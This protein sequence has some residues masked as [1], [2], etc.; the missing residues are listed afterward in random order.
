MH[1]WTA[2]VTNASLQ[3]L[4]Q[5]W[6]FLWVWKPRQTVS[7][8]RPKSLHINNGAR[9]IRTRRGPSC[10]LSSDSQRHRHDQE[11][12]NR[13]KEAAQVVGFLK[14]EDY[15]GDGIRAAR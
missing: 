3:V 11:G 9:F 2:E 1:I 12:K 14:T 7:S 4:I 8:D 5:H 13:K 15:M 10:L 6:G